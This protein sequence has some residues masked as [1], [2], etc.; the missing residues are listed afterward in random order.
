MYDKNAAFKAAKKLIQ[1][2]ATRDPEK[3]AYYMDIQV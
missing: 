3:L 2:Y 1:Q